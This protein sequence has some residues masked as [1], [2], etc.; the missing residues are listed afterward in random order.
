MIQSF[1]KLSKK[2]GTQD[3]L[4]SDAAPEQKYQDMHK[5]VMG[6]EQP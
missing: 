1:K 4:I 6:L 2:F 3:A 5:S